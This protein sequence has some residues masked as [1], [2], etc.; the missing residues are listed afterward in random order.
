[1]S[2]FVFVFFFVFSFLVLVVSVVGMHTSVAAVVV[3]GFG[4][5][6]TCG[7]LCGCVDGGE[8]EFGSIMKRWLTIRPSRVGEN[9]LSRYV[10]GLCGMVL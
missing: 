6:E 5:F 7:L 3:A 2:F 10:E 9:S 8:G 1:M 4:V